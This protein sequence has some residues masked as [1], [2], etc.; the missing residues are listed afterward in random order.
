MIEKNTEKN[1]LNDL[2]SEYFP[3]ET[4]L[5][6]LT[7]MQSLLRFTQSLDPKLLTPRPT[8]QAMPQAIYNNSN[9]KGLF[10]Q[11]KPNNNN[12]TALAM[13]D[14]QKQ[15]HASLLTQV[16]QL[17][18]LAHLESAQKISFARKLK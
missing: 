1:K 7:R 15:I 8:Q 18:D 5:D 14:T 2:F 12:T 10:H 4:P 3:D 13:T 17:R 9:N 16:K 6:I 11:F